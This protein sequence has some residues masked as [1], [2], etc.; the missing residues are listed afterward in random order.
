[1]AMTKKVK[2]GRE[3]FFD[4]PEQDRLLAMFTRLMAEHWALKERLMTVE[5]I[6]AAGGTVNE[7]TIEAFVP[8][9]ELEQR[10]NMRRDQ[11]V[12]SVFE[13]GQNIET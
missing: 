9:P 5:A 2:G 13:F 10:W 3:S 7:E 1:M 8:D 4:D 12:R 11:L 6:L